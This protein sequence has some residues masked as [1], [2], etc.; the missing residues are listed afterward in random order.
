MTVPVS[1]ESVGFVSTFELFKPGVGPSSS[2]TMGPMTAALRFRQMLA[3]HPQAG[4]VIRIIVELFG[5]LAATGGGHAT[6]RAAMLGLLGHDPVSIELDAA[7]LGLLQLKAD[8]RLPI[9]ATLT[10]DFTEQR[11]II[12]NRKIQHP[13]HANAMRIIALDDSG[14]EVLARLYFSIGGGFV[15]DEFEIADKRKMADHAAQVP[16]VFSNAAELLKLARAHN[17][18]I[19]DLVAAN[20]RALSNLPIEQRLDAIWQN[21]S[22]CI[23]LG[24]SAAGQ[25]PGGLNV[26]RRAQAI[27]E[28]LKAQPELLFMTDPLAAMDFVNV[29]ALA[30]NEENASGGRVVTAP[31]NGAAG[32][33][34]AV[35]RYL[36]RFCHGSPEQIRVFLLTAAAVGGLFKTNA[37][38][39]GAEVGCQGEVGVACSMAA[40]GLTA[41]LGGSNAQVENAAEIAMEHNLGLTCDPIGGLVQIPCIERNAIG[42]I[43]AIDASRLALLGDGQHFVSLDQVIATM[44][45]TGLDMQSKYKETSEG[46]LAVNH[47][48]C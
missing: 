44:L 17:L 43:K 10:V 19:A 15:L 1:V 4:S 39:S 11:D 8:R 38:I 7:S 24:L 20:E 28:K 30:V 6:D 26:P 34:P 40:A 41:A 25:L 18:S 37:S 33:V 22:N 14:T 21:M 29:W 27:F 42:A 47:V 3:A 2:H 48:A 32:I 45:Q 9:S 31:T 35:I 16:Y 36:V 46:G 5:S 12:W 23:D 13:Q